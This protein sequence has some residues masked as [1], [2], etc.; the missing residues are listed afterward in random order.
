MIVAEGPTESIRVQHTGRIVENVIDATYKVLDG[1]THAT[2]VAEQWKAL[3]LGTDEQ[4]ALATA[5]HHVRFADAQGHIDTPIAPSQLLRTRR[6]ADAGNDLWSTFNRVQE[7]VIKGGLSA[8]DRTPG[9]N[10]RRVTTREVKGIDG[11]LNLNKALWI[12]AEALA[13]GKQ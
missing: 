1:A 11:N 4:N 2:Q 13:K 6:M 12:I 10:A 9:A 8:I 7:N 3:P 5:A